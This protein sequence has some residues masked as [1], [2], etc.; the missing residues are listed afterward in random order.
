MVEVKSGGFHGDLHTAAY[1]VA[2]EEQAYIVPAK[3]M[4]MTV[5]D[6]LADHSTMANRILT[7]FKPKLSKAEYLACL[8]EIK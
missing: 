3:A 4:A 6:L 7:D 1:G 8:R 5:V 2:D